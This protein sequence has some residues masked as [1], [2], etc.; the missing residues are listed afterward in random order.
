L[1]EAGASKYESD[2]RN[3]RNLH[4]TDR[5]E[6]E[7]KP[8]LGASGKRESTGTMGGKNAK[9]ATARGRKAAIA[10]A[11]RAGGHTRQ[12]LYVQARHWH[13]EGRSKMSKRRLEN[14]LDIH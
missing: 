3:R 10:R 4:R 12:E 2:R 7:G 9:K 1:E 8:H 14:A 6:A 5:K 11:H 13:I